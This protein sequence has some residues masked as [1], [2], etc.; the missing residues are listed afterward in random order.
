MTAGLWE[1]REQLGMDLV[2]T[3]CVGSGWVQEGRADK[4]LKS[5][6]TRTGG[7]GSERGP[8]NTDLLPQSDLKV[9]ELGSE[10]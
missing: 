5:E 10:M 8:S 7:W 9:K 4:Y 1:A 6:V 2:Q 3:A